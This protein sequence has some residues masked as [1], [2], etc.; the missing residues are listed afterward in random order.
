MR[1][2]DKVVLIEEIGPDYPEGSTGVVTYVYPTGEMCNVQ[3]DHD[4]KKVIVPTRC[5]RKI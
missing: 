3:F 1:V 4:S 2:D 5:L